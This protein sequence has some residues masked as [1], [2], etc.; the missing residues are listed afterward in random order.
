[1]LWFLLPC[2]REPARASLYSPVAARL[3]PA[4]SRVL[5]ATAN[6]TQSGSAPPSFAEMF[7]ASPWLF[8]DGLVVVALAI[9]AG[10][11]LYFYPQ[12]TERVWQS[13]GYGW[14]PVALW[15][16]TIL[17]FLRYGPRLLPRYWRR[18]AVAGAVVA[19]SLAALS[20][21][22]PPRGPLEQVSL[23]GRWGMEIGGPSLLPWGVAKMAGILTF[24]P[25]ALY[26]RV[27]GPL[28]SHGLAHLWRWFQLA[29]GYAY[30]GVRRL[31]ERMARGRQAMREA[32][33][34][35]KARRASTQAETGR[36]ASESKGGPDEG[37]AK[38]TIADIIGEDNLAKGKQED[39]KE[40]EDEDEEEDLL[41]WMKAP[42]PGADD[43]AEGAWKLPSLELL[44]PP[45]PVGASEEEFG[46]MAR[47]VEQA[48]ADHGVR[49]EVTD[50]RAGPRVVQFGL[51]PGWV[52]RRGGEEAGQRSRVKVQSIITREKDLA[53]ALMTP[54][55]RVEAPVPGAA[56]VGLEVPVPTPTKVH[57]RA[58]METAEFRKLA[59]KKGLPIAMGQD[60]GGAPVA[61]DLASLP[62]MLIAGAT[63]SGKS[64]MI[65]SI[66]ASFLLTKTPDQL[67]LLMVDP[68]RV[69]LTPFN[70]IPHLIQPVI[71]EAEEVTES[72]RGL[73][74]EMVRR[75]K[76]MEE[77]G[78][79]NIEVYNQRAD[80][81]M[82]F[83]VLIVDEL[84]DLMM[85]AGFEVEQNLVRL[86]QLGRAAGIHL[87][88]AT[89]RPS[90]NVVTGLLKANVP[91]RCAFAV[92][93]QVDS[94]VI[95]DS[96]GAE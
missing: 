75:Y 42:V 19:L 17:I 1:M 2:G 47:Q 49:V 54:Y 84:A 37:Y 12:A 59:G 93:G 26:P 30:L 63:G 11:F 90:V 86:A 34:R 88:L 27:I 61:L 29:A 10:S 40:E 32:R 91:A 15:A 9:I 14:A 8:V 77:Q 28:Y 16:A 56:L 72:L 68:K 83:L 45:E 69:E 71:V 57:L 22:Y 65:N 43:V 36:L 21:V 5:A 38:I 80:G 6:K 82:P 52:T 89:Q 44:A 60:T 79:R 25:L 51:S 35:A 58:V 95:L 24:V 23:A 31:N 55:L 53:L 78:V 18:L 94:R 67:R 64:V 92:S 48:L 62:H 87:L 46:D 73:N 13:L 76:K 70:G 39:Q 85:V 20:Y 41:A 33:S 4:G 7:R 81:K 74:R 50:I 3:Q 66:V 96:V